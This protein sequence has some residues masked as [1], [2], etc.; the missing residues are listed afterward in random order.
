MTSTEYLKI[1]VPLILQRINTNKAFSYFLLFLPILFFWLET[2]IVFQ[3][4]LKQASEGSPV[5][6][7][8][9]ITVPHLQEVTIY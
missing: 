1:S 8:N 6:S 9:V 5:P 7:N 4:S 2:L 3:I